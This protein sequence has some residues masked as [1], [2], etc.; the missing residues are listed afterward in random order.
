MKK[1]LFYG[2]IVAAILCIILGIYYLIPGIYHFVGYS[3][4]RAV[5]MT[6]HKLYAGAFFVLAVIGAAI[7]FFTRSKQVKQA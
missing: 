7:S 4:H 6:A 2:A 1:A 3:N 5:T